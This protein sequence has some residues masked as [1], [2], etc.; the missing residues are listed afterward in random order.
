MKVTLRRTIIGG[1]ATALTR[2][3]KRMIRRRARVLAMV[4][5]VSML[6][7]SLPASSASTQGFG[8]SNRP[9]QSSSMAAQLYRGVSQSVASIG[10]WMASI[11]STTSSPKTIEYEPVAAYISPAPPFIDAPTNLTVTAASAS[12]ISLSW[13]APGGSVD[14]YAI[15]RA[16]NIGGPFFFLTN[17]TGA[18]THADN[19]VTNLNSYLYRVR[20][21]TALGLPSAPSNMAL[22]TAIS[23]EFTNPQGQQIKAQHFYDVRTAINSA[24]T[25]GNLTTV[26]WAR[27]NLF[28][29]EVLAS[30]VNELRTKLD[31]ALTALSIPV[32]VYTDPTLQTGASGTLIKGVHI[33]ELQTRSTKGS[34]TSVGPIDSDSSTARLDPLNETGGGGENPLSRNFNWSLPLVGLPGRS[35]LD[36]ALG[37]SYNSLVWT[38]VGSNAISFDN[39]A[40][41][42]TA[43]F[44]L[45]YPTIQQPYFNA[46]VG[47]FAFL[48][49]NS[50]GSRTE[51]RQVGTSD[52]YAAADSSH[53]LLDAA[54]MVLRSYDGTQMTYALMGSVFN[55][56]QVKD[57]N[58]NYITLNYTPAGRIDTVVDT[59]ARS[60]KF[61]YDVNGWLTSITQVWNQGQPSQV[62]HNW[63]R[64]EYTNVSIDYNFGSMNVFGLADSSTLKMLS[65]VKLADDSYFD[66]SYTSWGQVWKITNFAADNS[67]INYRSYNLPQTTAQHGDCPRFTSR[68]DWARYWNGD[69]DGTMASNEEATTTFMIPV[70][71][72]WTMP[73]S[74]QQTGMRCEVTTPDGKL[75]KIYYIGVAGTTSGWRRGLQA[76]VETHSG[77]TW[78]RKVM[79]TWTQDNTSVSYPLNPRELETNIY[80]PSGNRKRTETTYQQFNFA[81]GTSCHFLR[82]TYEY[83]A[84]ASTRLRSTRIDYNM[85]AVYTD[86]RIIGLVSER[87]LYEGDVNGGGPLKARE[88]FFYDNENGASSIQGN[89]AP[90]Q[91]DNTNFT[92]SFVSGRGNLSSVRRYNVDDQAQFTTT[93]SKYNTAG[94]VVSVKDA[95][96]HETTISYAESFSDGNNLRNT[97]AYPTN[98]T[99]A[100]LFSSTKKYHFDSGAVTATQTPLPNGTTN[101][102]GPQQ[103]YTYDSIGRLQ[104]VSNSVTSLYTRIEY[105][106]NAARRDTFTTYQDSLGE[107]RSFKIADGHGRIVASATEHPGSSGGYSAVRTTYDVMGRSIATSNPAETAASGVPSQWTTVGDDASVGWVFTQQTYDW[108]GR[109][110]VTTNPSMTSNPAETTTKEISYSTC[111]C[112]GGDVIT[113]TDEGTIDAGIAKRRQQK[114]YKDVLGR[115]VK[116]ENLNW[117]SGTVYNSTVNTYDVRDLITQKREY[118]GAEGSP[119]FQDT[120]MTYDG[121]ARPKTKHRP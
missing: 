86:R 65:R 121:H 39:D 82:D 64:F 113:L 60:I 23:F 80:D 61:N 20:A 57:R 62:T 13:T 108:R 88:A 106:T 52:L 107:A 81:N 104:Q 48:L 34:S 70:S 27:S 74:T 42:P 3:L 55:C 109:P 36:L 103:L 1:P 99:D 120:N 25:I 102:P 116:T 4:V 96:N 19:T 15:E 63:A 90:I 38:K 8:A 89:D 28:G 6:A 2:G 111:G 44:R 35:G 31:E 49:I 26:T 72:T 11:F 66:F 33:Q 76:L 10:N 92:S 87:K 9:A 112:A 69:T 77:G 16:T 30:D 29:L 73:D 43:G 100:D 45:G 110:L 79:T 71:D 54:T 98:T 58:G 5:V 117:E 37:L 114:I 115:V 91:H 24:R 47:K 67:P 32:T 118:D 7:A 21:V 101:T 14:H 97:L 59:L 95:S 18:T 53:L 56:T 12:S 119:T 75:D 41:F 83:A 85:S 94:A 50:D 40:G 68:K 46:E 93:F 51:L 78:R 105:S 22:G 84:N 17:V